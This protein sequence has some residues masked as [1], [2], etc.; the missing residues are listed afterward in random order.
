[1]KEADRSGMF[2]APKK[3]LYHII[4]HIYLASVPLALFHPHT[5]MSGGYDDLMNDS[6]VYMTSLSYQDQKQIH[7]NQHHT[8]PTNHKARKHKHDTTGKQ[9]MS[10]AYV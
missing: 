9:K 10:P 3:L 7:V 6:W 8:R 5:T 2:A 4:Y 1:M